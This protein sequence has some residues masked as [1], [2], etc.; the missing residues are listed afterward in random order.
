ME[1]QISYVIIFMYN[2]ICG[3]IYASAWWWCICPFRFQKLLD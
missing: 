2:S 3:K 1:N